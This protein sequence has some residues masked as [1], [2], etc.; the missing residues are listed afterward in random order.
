MPGQLLKRD[1]QKI[2]MS[3]VSI[4]FIAMFVVSGIDHR[5]AW[6]HV[7]LVLVLIGDGMIALSF[8]VYSLVFKANR[9]AS[10][11]IEIAEGQKVISTGPYSLIRHPMYFGALFF[12]V[13]IPF[14]LGSFWAIPAFI[15]LL[16]GLI[17]RIVDEEKFLNEHLDGYKEYCSKVR[18]RLIPWLY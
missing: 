2:I 16:P 4:L 14:A 8:V 12:L 7:P 9:F 10:S 11:T 3:W 1:S 18:Y 5:L 15:A 6:S 13:G 17:W